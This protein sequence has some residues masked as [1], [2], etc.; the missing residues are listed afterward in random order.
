MFHLAGAVH[1]NT[2]L[3]E[4]YLYLV[5]L[6]KTTKVCFILSNRQVVTTKL[7]I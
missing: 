6:I 4:V 7:K 1:N 5:L 3:E 2:W